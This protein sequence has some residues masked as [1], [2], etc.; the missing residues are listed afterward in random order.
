VTRREAPRAAELGVLTSAKLVSNTALRWVGPFLPTLERAFGASTS[1]LT[2]VMG[3]A[4][5]GGLTTTATGRWLDRGLQ[6]TIFTAGLIAVVASSAIA[7][8]GSTVWFA[9][10][11][12][13]L[14]IGVANLTV[15]GHTWISSRVPYAQRGR[16]IGL[17]ETSW[18]FALLLGAPLIAL[19]I[20]AGGWRAPYIGLCIAAVLAVILVRATI[21]ADVRVTAA[22]HLAESGSPTIPAS[23]WLT[24]VAS[25]L[26]AAA[27][28]SVFIVSGTWLEDR[29]EVS[30]GGL[31]LV[32]MGFGALELLASSSSAFLADRIGK[33]RSVIVGLAVLIGGLALVATSGDSL[34]IAILGLTTFLAGFEFGFVT[35]LSLVTEAAPGARGRAIGFGNAIGTVARA[36]AVLVSGRLYDAVGIGGSL[37]LSLAAATTAGVLVI[38]GRRH[39]R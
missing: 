34:P 15:A 1:T 27:G 23:A 4:E 17:F 13:V 3:V 35:G 6:R 24:L 22:T 2:T 29:H 10:S 16:A 8:G 19:A 38:I 36:S 20:D 28:L 31:G 11:F 7:L 26:I 25:A 21:P 30:T 9:V 5:L 12:A 14:V 33:R 18:A 32:A 39:E 37:S